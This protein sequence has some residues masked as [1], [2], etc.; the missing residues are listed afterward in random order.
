MKYKY[1]YNKSNKDIKHVQP[2]WQS[3]RL[4]LNRHEIFAILDT[5]QV[6][7]NLSIVFAESNK[8]WAYKS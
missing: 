8:I 7:V 4:V 6:T 2:Y 5:E 3:F 1:Q